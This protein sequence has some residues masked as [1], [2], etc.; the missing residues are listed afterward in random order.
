MY[1]YRCSS[2]YP[3]SRYTY[4]QIAH[5][6]QVKRRLDNVKYCFLEEPDSGILGVFADEEKMFSRLKGFK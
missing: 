3:A 2:P 4:E 5:T 1:E 6:D